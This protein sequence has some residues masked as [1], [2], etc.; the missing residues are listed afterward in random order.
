[1]GTLD[2]LKNF[3]GDKNVASIT[4]S[5]E[6]TVKRVCQHISFEKDMVIVEYGPGGGVFTKYL[7]EKMT[8][9]SRLIAFET[10]GG[11]ITLLSEITD[12][13][14]QI[15]HNSAEDISHILQEQGITSVD[16][17]ISGIPF[18]FIPEKTK[19]NIVSA[20]AKA[21]GDRGNFLVYQTSK[22]MVPYLKEAF[23]H[24]DTEL[25]LK[26]IPPMSVMRAYQ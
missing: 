2:Y 7:L 19:R 17:V 16:Y 20:T 21:L 10:N 24:V 9:N 1:M 13:R 23:T 5:S 18:S 3:F 4:P 14:F 15:F 8:P 22:H 11:F 25:E 12:P 26:N 6:Y